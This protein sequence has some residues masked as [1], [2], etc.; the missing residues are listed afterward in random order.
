MSQHEG[1]QNKRTYTKTN[2]HQTDRRTCWLQGARVIELSI[3]AI[4]EGYLV[5]TAAEHSSHTTDQ[6]DGQQHARGIPAYLQSH[7][8]RRSACRRIQLRLPF[9]FVGHFIE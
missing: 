4:T 9:A 3:T 8:V 1:I 5:Q 7:V 6:R 2:L